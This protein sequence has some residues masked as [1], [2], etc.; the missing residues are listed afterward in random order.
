MKAMVKH[1]H[2]FDAIT[3]PNAEHVRKSLTHLGSCGKAHGME[4]KYI[5]I[6]YKNRS[7]PFHIDYFKNY[8]A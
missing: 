5:D 4:R 1:F 8:W 7:F 6:T 2:V 3:E